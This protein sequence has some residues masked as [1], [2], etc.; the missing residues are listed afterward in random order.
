MH[1]T[2]SFCA[3]TLSINFVILI[4]N[5]YSIG[6]NILNTYLE[7]FYDTFFIIVDIDGLK[8]L[9]VFPPSNFCHNLIIT[10]LP[11]KQCN[12][13]TGK[14]SLITSQNFSILSNPFT[15]NLFLLIKFSSQNTSK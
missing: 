7:N 3:R 8:N 5:N 11:V 4:V 12:I 10:L 9:T 2:N 13:T 1:I 15:T 14:C 6:D